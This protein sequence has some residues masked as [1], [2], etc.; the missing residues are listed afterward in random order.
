MHVRGREDQIR[1]NGYSR[2]L[3]GIAAGLGLAVIPLAFSLPLYSSGETLADNVGGVFYVAVGVGAV[4]AALPLLVPVEARRDVALI[5]G[6]LLLLSSFVTALGMFFIPS[7]ALLCLVA[8][9]SN[10]AART[11]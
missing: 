10:S 1:F 7:G 6:L 5:S 4:L 2:V 8:L 11:D 9:A 3:S